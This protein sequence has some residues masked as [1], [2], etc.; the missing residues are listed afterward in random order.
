MAPA[1][2][3]SP[4]Q[5]PTV[6]PAAQAA[7]P[8]MDL[9]PAASPPVP[10]AATPAAAARSRAA[11]AHS[12][13]AA[14]K[15]RVAA[16]E[17]MAADAA[18][19]AAGS[20]ARH[21]ERGDSSGGGA[22]EAGGGT[23][24][25]TTDGDM[26]LS[27]GVG[28]YEALAERIESLRRAA[29]AVR[30][31]AASEP[32]VAAAAAAAALAGAHVDATSLPNGAALDAVIEGSAAALDGLPQAL[33]E[34]H[35]AGGMVRWTRVG[36]ALGRLHGSA[37]TRSGAT[38]REAAHATSRAAMHLA[39][40][41]V[42][43]TPV[44]TAGEL[45][46]EISADL[47]LM[48]HPAGRATIESGCEGALAAAE[49][50]VALAALT[51]ASAVPAVT[52]QPDPRQLASEERRGAGGRRERLDALRTLSGWYVA[53]NG[54]ETIGHAASR[55]GRAGNNGT[56]AFSPLPAP[57]PPSMSQGEEAVAEMEA[58][59]AAMT[60]MERLDVVLSRLPPA[61]DR[62]VRALLHRAS[63]GELARRVCRGPRAAVAIERVLERSSNGHG[64][65]NGRVS[66]GEAVSSLAAAGAD[67]DVS[68]PTSMLA[69][70]LLDSL[71]PLDL[72]ALCSGDRRPLRSSM[73]PLRRVLRLLQHSQ[74]TASSH[75]TARGSSSAIRAESSRSSHR[76]A[77]ALVVPP[78]RLSAPARREP[79]ALPASAAPRTPQAVETPSVPTPLADAP[80]LVEEVEGGE[81]SGA[82]AA[83]GGGEAGGS[84][85]GGT[86]GGVEGRAAESGAST[87]LS[88]AARLANW[89]Q[90]NYST[91]SPPTLPSPTEAEP[92]TFTAEPPTA[93]APAAETASSEQ[94]PTA[95][96]PEQPAASPA[97]HSPSASG[98]AQQ[99]QP[100]PQQPQA[101]SASH[102]HAELLNAL[103]DSVIGP[104]EGWVRDRWMHTRHA[105]ASASARGLASI[106]AAC[107]RRCR[108]LLLD[109][110]L[111]TLAL[112]PSTRAASGILDA[113]CRFAHRL[114]RAWEAE[115]RMGADD[116]T[117]LLGPAIERAWLLGAPQF[118]PLA[119]LVSALLRGHMLQA[120]VP[121]YSE[122]TLAEDRRLPPPSA[123][124][125][126]PPLPA[127]VLPIP[128]P[129]LPPL[130]LPPLPQL[131][132][133]D[134]D[135]DDAE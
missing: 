67:A 29:A 134:A 38:A 20:S 35:T 23:D 63:V 47:K 126:A 81:G 94:R 99:Q 52:A 135:D 65:G 55:G 93:A 108:S 70:S 7:D 36:H 34:H 132:R 127:G 24:G 74:R 89:L 22:G 56:S 10:T 125:A 9:P 31:A 39:T 119:P 112:P 98:G 121:A 8:F 58:E 104:E 32:V 95:T 17:V 42:D 1:A 5:A 68:S 71:M 59:A 107:H 3:A 90:G 131:P 78:P 14:A 18:A 33:V 79:P 130:A 118:A 123:L 97:L 60:G 37:G 51:A 19:L 50:L 72:C 129:P 80:L 54:A 87:P 84:E 88:M 103:V 48:L 83:E 111:F 12:V 102:S 96:R 100:L 16:V 4:V 122:Y 11:L 57:L 41:D 40:E 105:R 66:S 30:D 28:Y 64:N 21:S 82:E 86:G 128:L 49:A 85:G 61:L 27:R 45:A 133:A 6:P 73:L 76:R 115:L 13:S 92:Q 26:A 124:P 15:A 106:G 2:S 77:P 75:H 120:F 44:F 113:C 46:A 25:G 109:V 101:R 62:P 91:T 43:E 53:T 117:I 110:C 114:L 69:A 116:V